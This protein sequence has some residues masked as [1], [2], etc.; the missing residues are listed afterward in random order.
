MG[1]LTRKGLMFILKCYKI[2]RKKYT[3]YWRHLNML[4]SLIWLWP[5]TTV[6]I[7]GSRMFIRKTQ[8]C[9]IQP[10]FPCCLM[11]FLRLF[12][13]T[14]V[15]TDLMQLCLCAVHLCTLPRQWESRKTLS[16]MIGHSH[17]LLWIIYMV[18]D[19]FLNFCFPFLDL[20]LEAFF[21]SVL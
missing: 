18:N 17:P 4:S 15:C 21:L 19:K 16:L 12:S 10:L 6:N 5:F 8:L 9:K 7:C 11:H 14:S 13:S 1:A 3:S 2:S 20:L